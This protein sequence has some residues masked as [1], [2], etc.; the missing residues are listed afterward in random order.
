MT[1]DSQQSNETSQP[2]RRR[3]GFFKE[4][5]KE[6]ERIGKKT[7]KGAREFGRKIDSISS[8]SGKLGRH[9]VDEFD[10]RTKFSLHKAKKIGK[11]I[12]D[13]GIDSMG[14]VGKISIKTA[15]VG[16]EGIL[17]GVAVTKDMAEITTYPYKKRRSI[18]DFFWKQKR[19]VISGAADNDPAGI[20]TYTQVGA[21]TGFSQLWLVFLTTPMLIAVE[22]M[23][24]RLGAVTKKGLNT[25]IKEKFGPGWAVFSAVLLML[26]NIGTIGADL[27]G[28]AAVLGILT[29]VSWQWFLAPIAGVFIYFLVA[30]KY[31]VI[32]RFLF[33]ITPILLLYIVTAIIVKPDWG[34][35]LAKTFIPNIQADISYWMAAVA[36]L[37]TTISAYL[38]FWETTQ[39][40]EEG[41]NI[42]DIAHEKTSVTIGM[43]F[44]NLV[45]YF[46]VIS[47]A[48]TLYANGINTV[49]TA[50]QAALALKPLAGNFAFLLF[51]IGILASGIIAVPVLAASTSYS[52][53][54][55]FNWVGGLK[56]K[57]HRAKA[58]YWVMILSLLV[59]A[60]LSLLGIKPMLMLFYSQIFQGV[61]TPIILIFLL[62]ICNDKKLLGEY[63]NKFWSNFWGWLTIIIMLGFSLLMFGEMIFK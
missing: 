2:P 44:C 13:M 3:W 58:F 5:K 63:A 47:A 8:A 21:A 20:A 31:S 49:E 37:G 6:A 34:E 12:V 17:T 38:I 33:I 42:K 25:V 9:V 27:A 60:S 32:S 22:E 1:N 52:M 56:H 57:F 19:G 11:D 4:T 54:N 61:L 10:P 7:I 62:L 40:I 50:D 43:I 41:K 53:A 30:G 26:C 16:R 59:G 14:L 46:I 36:V 39:E 48:A 24:A 23:S 45:F 28:M 18:F 51:T 35:V 55:T 29:G 15:H